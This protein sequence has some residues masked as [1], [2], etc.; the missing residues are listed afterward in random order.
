MSQ[1]D[2]NN[3]GGSEF[4]WGQLLAGWDSEPLDDDFVDDATPSSRAAP[5]VELADLDEPDEF[6]DATRMAS[7]LL[8]VADAPA[9]DEFI[10]VS[11]EDPKLFFGGD[12]PQATETV[13]PPRLLSGLTLPP[14]LPVEALLA[15]FAADGALEPSVSPETASAPAAAPVESAAAVAFAE[16]EASDERPI[17][18]AP[19]A[20]EKSPPAAAVAASVPLPV[21]VASGPGRVTPAAAP[22]VA[23]IGAEGLAA[24]AAW[25]AE[26]A[27]AK[28]DA[29]ARAR[30]LLVAAEIFSIVGEPS[31]AGALC[32]Q[33][34]ETAPDDP[35]A[36]R[37]ARVGLSTADLVASLEAESAGGVS[38]A[39]KLHAA[40]FAA[41]IHRT[42]GDSS[43]AEACIDQAARIDASDARV[44]ATRAAEALARGDTSSPSL[45]VSDPLV[46]EVLRRAVGDALRGRGGANSES[47]GE[48]NA[49]DILRRARAALEKADVVAAAERIAEL[50]ELAPLAQASTWLAASLAASRKASRSK[51]ASLFQELARGGDVAAGASLAARA[52]ELG[53]SAMLNDAIGAKSGLREID[54]I[55]LAALSGGDLR[56]LASAAAALATDEDTSAFARATSTLLFD[57]QLRANEGE[58]GGEALSTYA[59]IG[60]G[61]ARS[62]SASRVARLLAGGKSEESALLAAIGAMRETDPAAATTLALA[63]AAQAERSDILI[64]TLLDEGAA[65]GQRSMSA[66]AAGVIA[67]VAGLSARASAAFDAAAAADP[68]NRLALQARAPTGGQ[69]DSVSALRALAADEHEPRSAALALLMLIAHE[70]LL[71]APESLDTFVRLHTLLPEMPVGAFF[72]ESLGRRLGDAAEVTRWIEERAAMSSDPLERA[73]EVLRHATALGERD[74]SRRSERVAQ[75]SHARPDDV[76]LRDWVE[77]TA[78]EGLT[79]SGHW[80][81]ERASASTGKARASW[82]LRAALAFEREGDTGSML[83]TAR[84]AC[85]TDATDALAQVV[86]ER[87]ELASGEPARVADALLARGREAANPVTR[88]EAFERLA[89]LDGE[90]RKD[91]ASALLWHRTILEESPLHLPSLRHIEHVLVGEGRSDELGPVAASI[92]RALA[93]T[94]SGESAAHVFFASR[95]LTRSGEWSQTSELAAEAAAERVPTL[96]ALRLA[97]AHARAAGDAEAMLATTRALLERATGSTD[98]ATLCVRAAE[99]A[100]AR[101]EVGLALE[102][103]ERAALLEDGDL[104]TWSRL[105]AARSRAGNTG[106]AA[107]AHERLAQ[108]SQVDAHRKAAW[109]D[110]AL[111]WLDVERTS[112]ERASREERA[113]LALEHAANIDVGYKDVFIRLSA[114]YARSDANAALASL[115]ERRIPSVIDPDERVALEIERGRA[116]LACGDDSGGRDAYESALA[117]QPDNVD[118]LSALADLACARADWPAAEKAWVSLARLSPSGDDQQ[119]IYGQLGE[120]YFTRLE[121]FERAALAFLEVLKHAPS[122]VPA[123]QHLVDVYKKQGDGERALNLQQQLVDESSDQETKKR[124][125]VELASVLEIAAP[126]T[127]KAEQTL[128]AARREFPTDIGILRALGEYHLRHGQDAAAKLLFDRASADAL[129]AF[130]AGRFN[131]ALFDALSTVHELRGNAGAAR[132]V[133]AARAA[134]VGRPSAIGGADA[135]ALGVAFDSALAPEALLPAMRSLLDRT[136]AALDAA[137]PFD[138][139]EAGVRR[140]DSDAS[141]TRLAQQFADAAGLGEVIVLLAP[142]L[143]FAAVPVSSDPPAL[144]VGD[145]LLSDAPEATLVWA[146]ARAVK[147]LQLRGAVFARVASVEAASIVGG[148]LAA[149]QPDW[150]A[151]GVN[152]QTVSAAKQKISAALSSTTDPQLAVLARETAAALGAQLAAL[153]NNVVAWANRAALLATGDLGAALDGIAAASGRAGVT[154]AP[155]NEQERATWISR[156]PEAKDLVAFGVGAAYA[157]ARARLGL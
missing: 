71:D 75:A 112:P 151:P 27:A 38:P 90:V 1:A 23:A 52:L 42:V 48:P 66:L 68:T 25:L 41:E 95:V 152:A 98:Q 139:A 106:G 128:E 81:E 109:F 127:R 8:S 49:V 93:G 5:A 50:R 88:R 11:S 124:R 47:L 148:W 64:A 94:N 29:G 6:A 17:A 134:F 65:L 55:S 144:A 137:A 15:T 155:H 107:E 146:V 67:E 43:A 115:I 31:R 153:P 18:E 119:R 154:A 10:D 79:E 113:R 28:T 37:Q 69:I 60:A 123:R 140:A 24:T 102:L 91:P 104:V 78:P 14:P 149:F 82:L 51:S 61:S 58:A 4:D 157:D 53:D 9:E 122:D 72:G 150:V 63:V 30:G 135:R 97:N 133:H 99:V 36:I 141:V 131:P 85:A 136:G 13:E 142:A 103:L 46:A 3:K 2:G 32:A 70:S 22:S 117:I 56:P 35:L 34:L 108:G 84:E 33:A 20:I 40:L 74:A 26:E 130:A 62:R 101:G 96:W 21:E 77:R 80:R 44:I 111:C 87:A 120:L 118:A 110:A 59:Q 126:E 83:R 92:A 86:L 156:T 100:R 143:G 145:A 132:A 57:E 12:T 147:L 105:A 125:L 16:L 138:A 89:T 54:Q 45:R 19:L 129:R 116:L 121:N 73:V 7:A 114:L 76:A 39:A